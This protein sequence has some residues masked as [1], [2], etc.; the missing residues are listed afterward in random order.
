[1]R[2]ELEP[3]PALELRTL[4]QRVSFADDLGDH[5]LVHRVYYFRASLTEVVIT[6]AAVV[7][8]GTQATVLKSCVLNRTGRDRCVPVS[9][10]VPCPH[11][12]R[13]ARVSPAFQ[14]GSLCDVCW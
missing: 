13:G 9:R 6:T 4:F 12:R 5:P 3:P 8:A 2:A 14:T 11:A 10:G 1:M 7:V